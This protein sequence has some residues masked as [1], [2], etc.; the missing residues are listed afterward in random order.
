MR[1]YRL[2]E[3]SL[4]GIRSL[5]ISYVVRGGVLDNSHISMS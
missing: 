3:T 1:N 2:K 4:V 5:E